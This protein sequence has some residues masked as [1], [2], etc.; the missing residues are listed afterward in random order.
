MLLKT[1]VTIYIAAV[2]LGTLWRHTHTN[3]HNKHTIA[4][5]HVHT[6]RPVIGR[7]LRAAAS[8]QLPCPCPSLQATLG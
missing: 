5:K 6:H 8:C 3:A 7:M 4:Q 2:D 1:D